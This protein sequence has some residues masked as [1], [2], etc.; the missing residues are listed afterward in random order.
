ML[1]VCKL[2][3]RLS[4]NAYDGEITRLI[5]AAVSDLGLVNVPAEV[6]T[7]DPI[8]VQAIVTYVRLHFGTP[9]DY[10]KLKASYD[11]QKAQLMVA[12]GYGQEA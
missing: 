12:T 8:L 3:M 10:D 5:A 9:E 2:A 7:S 6:T 1:A 4:T 11:E